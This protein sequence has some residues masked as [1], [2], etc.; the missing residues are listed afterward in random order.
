M[1]AFAILAERL[2]IEA[3]QHGAFDDLPGKG[4]PL[5][6]EDL[7]GVPEELRMG[8]KLLKNAG[9][10]P[11]ELELISLREPLDRCSDEE[12]RK[13][14]KKRLTEKQLHY[15]LL[16]ER[17]RYNPAFSAYREKLEGRFGF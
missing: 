3:Q 13:I 4:K 5:S 6:M 14:L 7:S 2:I 10:L 1:Q 11:P 16:S 15:Q 17:N 12:E 8:Y 9:Y